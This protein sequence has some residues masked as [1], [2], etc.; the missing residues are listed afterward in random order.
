MSAGLCK[1]CHDTVSIFHILLCSQC[2]ILDGK[3]SEW[4]IFK[5]HHIFARTLPC[6]YNVLIVRT[7]V[8]C[9][10]R[11]FLL[12][13]GPSPLCLRGRRRRMR[14]RTT[15][16]PSTQ[17][18]MKRSGCLQYSIPCVQLGFFNEHGKPHGTMEC[19]AGHAPPEGTPPLQPFSDLNASTPCPLV[20]Y[21]TATDLNACIGV[22]S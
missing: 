7:C 3:K 22:N 18:E 8:C 21:F 9:L 13:H 12:S 16:P 17:T 11:C 19:I 15:M 1:R 14:K 10:C 5:N 20:A 6:Q 4:H 2:E